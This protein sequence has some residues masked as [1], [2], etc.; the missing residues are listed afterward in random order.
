MRTLTLFLVVLS[1]FSVDRL[2]SPK[3]VV[4]AQEHQRGFAPRAEDFT[5]LWWDQGAPYY[6]TMRE[7]G[8]EQILCMQSGVGGVMLD[9]RS[10]RLLH[11]GRFTQ[12]MDMAAALQHGPQD[13]AQLP[14]ADL[15]LQITHDGVT[16]R[17]A[18]RGE[19]PKDE[20]YFPVRFIESGRNL[21]RVAIEGIQFV[22]DDQ[23]PREINGRL[24]IAFWP[25]RCTL[26]FSLDVPAQ[27]HAGEIAIVVEGRRVAAPLAPG[28]TVTTQLLTPQTLAEPVPPEGID[29]QWDAGLG[30]FVTRLPMPPWKNSQGTYYP[31]DELDR[32]DRWP[33]VLRNDSDHDTVV[34]LMFVPE[35]MPAITGLTPMLC[36]ADG[37]PT[38][39]PVQTS[40]NWH[41]RPD[42]GDLPH[43]GPWVHAC[44]FVRLPPHAQRELVFS[45]TYARWGG[46]P[47]ASHAQLSLVGWGH[48][49]FWDQAAIGSFGES[50]C[51]EPGRVQRR[52]FITDVRPLMTRSRD[53][54][55]WAWAE[56]CGG[57][58]FLLW[59]DE[60]GNYQAA[61][62]T[63]SD[64]RAQGPCL[65]DVGYFEET[66]DGAIATRV[67]VSL[68]RSDDYLRTFLHLRYDVRKPVRWQRLAFFQ[69]GADYYNETP[70]L[71]VAIGNANEVLEE[72]KPIQGQDQYDRQGVALRGEQPWVSIHGVDGARVRPGGAAV[73]RGL[74]VRRWEAV[75]G[76]QPA[77]TPHIATFTNEWGKDNFKTA[78]E[79]ALPP[80]VTELI[81]GDFVDAEL[82][83]IVVPI[84][85]DHYYGPNDPFRKLLAQQAD[86]PYFVLRE[87]AGNA[88][89]VSVSTGVMQRRY[90]L[91]VATVEQRAE[92]TVRGGVGYIPVTFS[93]VQN[94]RG[95]QLHLDGTVLNQ[96]VH[97]NDF[98]QT[99]Y[100][101][102]T[103]TW[104]MTF[105]VLLDGKQHTLSF[106]RSP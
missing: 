89:D 7:K 63:R 92:L 14:A 83:V 60:N 20:F 21:Q 1:L 67:D 91:S 42:K 41:A 39:L 4:A 58:D 40:K 62:R 45:L 98:W 24:E 3:S 88:L 101:A 102:A 74:I 81:P 79:L 31:S 51:F 35:N 49:Q 26:T 44:A 70:A 54:G 78:I 46:V 5:L 103:D 72:W 96:A 10:L 33:L 104:Q 105:N 29:A 8:P 66:I 13:L 56:N 75:L 69:M 59:F 23:Q 68:P 77:R 43:Q 90:P 6:L 19:D 82:E 71:S 38:G 28:C 80:G 73:T 106:S 95:Y 15:Q 2:C 30:A 27:W 48:N 100:D 11:V 52:C 22:A 50:I 37:T 84:D 94:Y 87:A 64:Y 85:A 76:G 53:G 9:T 36:D 25:D 47:A 93:N 55:P 34:P 99:Q 97:G 32:L 18:G 61:R 12:V 17:C 86:T 65:T 16:Y 57:G